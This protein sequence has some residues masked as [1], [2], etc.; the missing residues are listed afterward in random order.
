MIKILL[1]C[2]HNSAR[3]QMAEAFVNNAG[4]ENLKAE[5]AGIEKGKLNPIVVDAMKEIGIDISQNKTNTVQEKI[6]SGIYFDYVITVCDQ[7]SGERCP[8]FPGDAYKRLHIEFEDPSAFQG[9][10]EEKLDFT[11]NVRDQIEI[12]M[13]EFVKKLE[14]E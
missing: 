1:V 9:T 11:R 8:I 5:S 13:N 7:A 2:I 10:Y 14:K 3:S 4:L 12:K 6:D